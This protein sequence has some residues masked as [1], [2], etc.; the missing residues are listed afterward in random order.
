[1]PTP[2]PSARPTRFIAAVSRKLGAPE[3]TSERDLVAL[4]ERRLPAASIEALRTAGLSDEE[5][6]R[7]LIP[8]R[9]LAHRRTK[10]EPLSREESDRALRIARILT[11]AERTF[12]SQDKALGWMRK[13][14]HRFEGRSPMDMLGTE[15]GARLVEEAIVQ[16]D[17]GMAA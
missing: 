11:L 15:A 2:R 6:F 5:I 9:T 1:M 10:N 16:I 3:L 13:S 12:A 4:V 7:L 8:R 17:D 14:K